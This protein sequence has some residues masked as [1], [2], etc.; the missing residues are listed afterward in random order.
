MSENLNSLSFTGISE[1]RNFSLYKENDTSFMNFQTKPHNPSIK[2]EQKDP[3]QNHP[4]NNSNN[5]PKIILKGSTKLQ[6]IK[7]EAAIYS[8]LG[9][10]IDYLKSNFGQA[11]LLIEA[12]ESFKP[13]HSFAYDRDDDNPESS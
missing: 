4:D 2:E 6:L 3:N 10:P 11:G 12:I 8:C 9:N 1:Q 7:Q 13:S 5:E